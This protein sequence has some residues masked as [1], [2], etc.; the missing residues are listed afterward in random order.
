MWKEI[1][2]KSSELFLKGWAIYFEGLPKNLLYPPTQKSVLTLESS[3]S[4]RNSIFADYIIITDTAFCNRQWLA[5]PQKFMSLFNSRKV[6]IRGGVEH[7][8]LE[9]KDTKKIRGQ[10]QPFRGQNLSRPRTGVRNARGQGRRRRCSPKKRKTS[11][12]IFFRR[13]PI[14]WRSQNF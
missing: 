13:S 1:E 10:G 14:Y 5:N 8:R 3:S 7:T 2:S 6:P 4:R 12:K 11:S 9:A